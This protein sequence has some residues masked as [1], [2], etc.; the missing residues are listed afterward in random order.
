MFIVADA[1]KIRSWPGKSVLGADFT[2]S[3]DGEFSLHDSDSSINMEVESSD[4]AVLEDNLQDDEEADDLPKN[5]KGIIPVEKHLGLEVNG[6]WWKNVYPIKAED[7]E[8]EMWLL[9][10]FKMEQSKKLSYR[11]FIGKVVSIDKEIQMTFLR[12]RPSIKTTKSVFYFPE[13]PDVCVITA[14]QI[15][16]SVIPDEPKHKGR[17]QN[18]FFFFDIDI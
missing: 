2:D 7:V 3:S 10:S 9:T 13:K 15:V 11:Y 5:E 6:R 18:S 8:P 16:G 1:S 12:S 4:E 17:R 14:D